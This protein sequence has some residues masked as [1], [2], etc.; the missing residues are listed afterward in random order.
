M[1]GGV[2]VDFLRYDIMK[3]LDQNPTFRFSPDQPGGFTSPY[4]A[5]MQVGNPDLT[6]TNQQ[7]GAY[8][9]DDWTLARKLT[10]N[11]GVRWD[12]ETDQLNNSFVTPQ[13]VRDSVN[14][15]LA[16]YPFFNPADYFTDGTQRP[17]FYGAFQPRLGFAWD[18]FN[19]GKTSVRAA[20]ALQTDQP[21]TRL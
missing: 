17:R 2:S 11:L 16:Q 10:L 12:F 14:A 7:F 8:I 19:D 3:Q 5:T 18:P 9:Q 13:N 15:F 21:M 1:K 4:Q 20:Y 6:T